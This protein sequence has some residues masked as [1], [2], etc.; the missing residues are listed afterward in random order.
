MSAIGGSGAALDLHNP[1]PG[2][3]QDLTAKEAAKKACADS[4][5]EA[6]ANPILGPWNANPYG[7]PPFQSITREHLLPALQ[8][9]IA[10]AIAAIQDICVSPEEPTFANTV[11]PYET[12][13]R[14]NEFRRVK[15]LYEYL[16]STAAVFRSD[17]VEG[18][19]FLLEY[20]THAC[21]CTLLHRLGK[22]PTQHLAA[23]DARLV[24]VLIQLVI[25]NGATQRDDHSA[26]KSALL[27]EL[28][29]LVGAYS[30]HV[31]DDMAVETELLLRDPLSDSDAQLLS[32][33]LQPQQASDDASVRR[34]RVPNSPDVVERLLAQCSVREVR[35]RVWT[36]FRN[37]GKPANY[38]T[39]REILIIKSQLSKIMGIPGCQN[40]AEYNMRNSMISDPKKVI[41]MYKT[42]VE[43]SKKV[44]QKEMEQMLAGPAQHDG[45]CTP[46]DFKHWDYKYYS[47]ALRALDDSKISS[48]Q[49]PMFKFS[50]V[51][52]GLC[53]LAQELYGVT[54]SLAP[55]APK[56]DDGVVAYSL[57]SPAEELIGIL[58]VDVWAREGK[59]PGNWSHQIFG[60]KPVVS[61]NCNFKR[62]FADP[63][64][65]NYDQIKSC[66]LHEFGHCLHCLFS[67]VKYLSVSGMT[68]PDDH[69]ELPSGL[70]EKFLSDPR[71]LSKLTTATLPEGVCSRMIANDNSSIGYV[72]LRSLS[73]SILDLRLHTLPLEELQDL[74]IE[75][76]EEDLHGELGIPPQ[77]PYLF[78]CSSFDHT[79]RFDYRYYM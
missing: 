8:A 42:F 27:T 67:D 14:L 18:D 55:D 57:K 40:Y 75:K 26:A 39:A 23:E 76:F 29:V 48:A 1:G 10:G 22:V 49:L 17:K 72:L 44:F 56:I 58:Y 12:G 46:E 70:H 2:N 31:K 60:S 61:L 35:E 62:L 54:M 25:T 7:A 51:M 47:N 41:E 65:L 19:R 45:I 37:R 77:V 78:E 66:L 11:I 9:C 59:Q 6:D 43:P 64:G 33:Y 4:G 53:W 38:Q 71:F 20:H 74:N 34:Y 5:S 30:K 32:V 21:Q 69:V 28:K 52:L 13:E 24:R 79:F 15:S 73:S 3:G 36:N 63:E 50:E 68:T 16:M